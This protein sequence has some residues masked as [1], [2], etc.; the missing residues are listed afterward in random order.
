M[1]LFKDITIKQKLQNFEIP[2]FDKKITIV[3]KWLDDYHNGTLKKDNEISRA[4]GYNQDFFF[5]I[6]NYT[7]KPSEK[8]TFDAEYNLN[9]KR[10]DGVLGYF[11]IDENKED[12]ICAILELK[13]ASISLDQPQKREKSITPIEQGFGYKR[14]L[15]DCPFVLVSNFYEL[16]LYN[17]NEL[18]YEIWTLDDLVDEKDDYFNFKKFYYL[19]SEQN[20][21][22][23]SEIS[24]T[25]SLLSEIRLE[26]QE[27]TKKFYKDYK[28]RRYLLLKNLYQKN[29]IL[30]IDSDLLIEKGQKLIDRIIFMCFAEDR[31]LL[32]A[33]I[34]QSIKRDFEKSTLTA[35]IWDALKQAFGYVNKGNERW[36]IPDGYN[37][38]LFARDDVFD[39]LKV[40]N[41]ILTKVIDF[42]MYDFADELSVNILGH[43][44][45]QSISDLELI[46]QKIEEKEFIGEEKIEIK[47][48]S[49]RKKDGI[50]YTPEYIVDYIV[51]NSL[52]AYLREHE[53]KYIDEENLHDELSE[54]V[55]KKREIVAY[56][57]YQDF[58]K[59]VKVL[60]P[61]CGSGAFL[62]RV[63][64]YLLEENRRVGKILGGMF[65]TDDMYKSI[66]QNNI[67]GVDLNQESVE[68]TKLSLW[69]KSAQAGKKL[70]N[71]DNN[72][73]CGNSL[74]DDP[75]IAGDKAFKWEEEFFEI[76][77]SDGFDV[78][79]GNPP[80]G[81]RISKKEKKYFMDNYETAFYKLD[82]YSLFIEKALT[83][84]KEK[85][86]LSFIVP[87][88][89]LTIQQHKKL[90]E[91]I[92][93]YNLSQ[94]VNLPTKIFDDADLDTI[95]LFLRKIKPEDKI[96]I[97]VI[98]NEQILLNKK[99]SLSNIKLENDFIINTNFSDY[100][101]K[102]VEK[103]KEKSNDLD[104]T[105]DVSQ[106]YIP[107]RRSDLIKE[108]GKIDGN[109]IVDERLWHSKEKETDGFKQ[110]I[111]G[112]DIS[113]YFYKESHQY[114]KYGKHL[115]G[116]VDTKFFNSPR[117]LIMEVT[118][119][120]YYKL[121]AVFIEKEF[122][123]TP[124]IINIIEPSNNKNLLKFIL[125]L[126]NSRLYTWYHIKMNP[127]ANAVTSIPKILVNDV[128]RLPIKEISIKEQ[129]PFIEKADIMLDLNE[130]FYKQKSRFLKRMTDNYELEK[131]NK[132][133]EKF[134]EMEFGDFV[135]EMRKKGAKVGL[136]TQDELEEYF[137]KNKSELL[138]LD[139]HIKKTDND[140]DQMVYKLYGLDEEEIK[141]IEN[142]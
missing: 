58:L 14:Q 79:V 84:S 26:E 121:S 34:L 68:I 106:G 109:K 27:I 93:K 1:K 108:Y 53:M 90:R 6:L 129:K 132:K 19:L 48:V 91:Y 140:I 62:V 9:G 104:S 80:Y 73:K 23:E 142:K 100:D 138:E 5:D 139:T 39:D 28:E 64:D 124:S 128:R 131:A 98:E 65:N 45:E 4:P 78:I 3:Q 76:V 120:N 117:I 7:R 31:G 87:Y 86:I 133:L 57:K 70:S 113:R 21:I 130:K 61:A 49:K 111:Q 29:E 118:R 71:L 33:D 126:I 74:I 92:L 67:Y 101:Y 52:G 10:P 136:T 12:N 32:P 119:G 55:Y 69:L 85:G 47:K 8:A 88:T 75:E 41:H 77:G 36:D 30:R 72:I 56:T 115:A 89:C 66:L 137:D 125:L 59:Q 114:V 24:N 102:I 103:I 60:D 17:D 112:K 99:V 134:Y 105:F 122:Y 96:F 16:R 95:I 123:N 107:Y 35:T 82:S 13:G 141:I 18:D 81:A 127:K 42:G 110:E 94:I 83:L 40:D 22:S 25:E 51:K 2:D 43:I 15:R 11:H 63:F 44:F 50:F 97:G 20:L 54:S 37:G 135:K 38:G 46:K 116:Y